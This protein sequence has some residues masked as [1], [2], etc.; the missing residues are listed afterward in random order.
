MELEKALKQHFGYGE[1]RGVQKQVIETVMQQKNSLVVMPTGMGKSLC[2][3]L[4]STL[5]EGITVVIS[6][7]IALMKDQVDKAPNSL[8]ADFI[9]SSL[10]GEQKKQAYRKLQDGKIK[11]LYVT[12][13]RFRSDEFKQALSKNKVS[14][15]AVDEAH[16]ISEWGHD[17]RPDYTKL[18]EIRELVGN[19]T[20]IALTATA[21]QDV[22]KDILLQLGL[23]DSNCEKFIFG[24]RRDNLT[25]E[26]IDL[27]GLDQKVQAAMMLLNQNRG[28]CIIY[29]SLIDTLKKFSRELDKLNIPHT[30]YH[31]QLKDHHRKTNQ[32]EFIRGDIDLILATP[33]FGLGVD[34][35]DIRQVIHA[36]VPNSIEAYYQEVGRAGRDGEP[37]SCT[38]LFDED[39]ITIQI[40]F[41]KWA[42]PDPGFIGT[43][44]NL[45]ADHGD[46]IKVEGV[47]FLREKMN[48]YNRR[49]FRVETALNLL[50][51]WGCI[52]RLQHKPNEITVIAPPPSEYLEKEA[53]K[54]KLDNQNKRL[55]SL[56][57]LLQSD[58]P[59]IKEEIYE[60][61]GVIDDVVL[62]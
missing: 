50:E 1:F 28:P 35:P 34:K 4:P 51:R 17:F 19:P 18:K 59:D 44:F 22:Q 27:Y 38:L 48:F 37:S 14:L 23:D 13:E 26:V 52:Y 6:P 61:F 36:E 45:V 5:F 7:L 20:T 32:T 31:G 58:S 25:L 57:Q 54:R 16:C 15:F 30:Q 47:D 46:R 60:Y 55:L 9:N 53:H 40:D 41:I 12:P 33:A 42:S 8:G 21:T 3:Q 10:S 43:V 56:V 49:D 39:D 24:F 62:K 2:Y 29:F 11:L